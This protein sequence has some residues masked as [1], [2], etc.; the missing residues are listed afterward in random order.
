M[1]ISKQLKFIHRQQR[2]LGQVSANTPFNGICLTF[3]LVD[4]VSE[5]LEAF[6]LVGD[7]AFNGL[8][9]GPDTLF[10]LFGVVQ[11]SLER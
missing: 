8:L 11:Q 5:F 2:P 10:D 7:M 3:Q 9:E 4:I 6:A 1:Q